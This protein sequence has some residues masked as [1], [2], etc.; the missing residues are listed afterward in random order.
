M[1]LWATTDLL[2]LQK[3]RPSDVALAALVA[4]ALNELAEAKSMLRLAGFG[5][6]QLGI[7][8]QV[9]QAVERVQYLEACAAR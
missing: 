9:R 1:K 5:D 4:N 6:G 8:D 3:D 2:W 7:R